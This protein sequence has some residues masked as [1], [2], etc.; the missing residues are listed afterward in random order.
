MNLLKNLWRDLKSSP[1]D[2]VANW[3]DARL[4][5]LTMSG[6][7]ILLVV[8]AHSVFQH[9]VFMKPCE[10]CVYIRFAFLVMALGGFIAA[11]NPKNVLLKIVGYIF[12]F[13]GIIQGILFSVK[14]DA[15]HAAAHG[16][17]PFGVQGCSTEPSFPF[18]LPLDKW[19]PDWFAPTGDC[20]FDNPIVPEGAILS[21]LQQWMVDFYADGWYLIPSSHFMNM[22][23]ACLLAYLVCLLVLGAMFISWVLRIVKDKKLF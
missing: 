21:P 14:L 9:Y 4:L 16:D 11:I 23:Q 1:I 18:G 17:N 3:Q 22:A 20:G 13:Y 19:S 5:W 15:I 10:Q 7:S 6:L 8:I 2:T 12:G